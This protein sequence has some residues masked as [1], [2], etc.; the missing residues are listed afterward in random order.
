MI[1]ITHLIALV[2]LNAPLASLAFSSHPIG[3]TPSRLPTT[4]QNTWL[5][6]VRSADKHPTDGDNN[7]SVS[8]IPERTKSKHLERRKKEWISRSVRYYS[9]VMREEQRR[10]NGQLKVDLE[11][12]IKVENKF[13][14]M[15]TKHYFAIRKVKNGELK[16][17]ERLYRRIINELSTEDEGHCDHAKLAVST[18]LLSLLLQRMGDVKGTRSV[19]LNF[20]RL[21]TLSQEEDE[22]VECA[23]SAKVLQAF[24]L[25]EMKQGNTFKSLEL[26]TRAVKL[27]KTL[28]PVLLWKQ[29][30]DVD[31]RL[32]RKQKIAEIQR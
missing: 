12:E 1:W 31:A 6:A 15:A 19:F 13:V 23:C 30:R 17:A 14:E 27:D 32:G 2:A 20:F 29:F 28:A 3:S 16:H 18:L 24:G 26:V 10:R 9:T 22:D 7:L 25:F 4:H 11:Q 8:A 21:I 5:E